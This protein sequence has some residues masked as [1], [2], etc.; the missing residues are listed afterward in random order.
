MKVEILHTGDT[1]VKEVTIR[2]GNAPD[3]KPKR[4]V[5]LD[6]TLGAPFQ[7][8]EGRKVDDQNT[9]LQIYKSEGKLTLQ[10]GD[11]DPDTTHVIT[12]SLKKDSV[13]QSFGINT[14]KRWTVR[15]FVK[16][17]KTVAYY[18]SSRE[19]H[20]KLVRNLQAWSV[21]IEKVIKEVNDN[22]GNSE[23]LLQTKVNEVELLST[24]ELTIPVYQGHS[25]QI[26]RV[27]IGLDPR[28][29]AVDLYLISDQLFELEIELREWLIE[30]A[31]NKFA[32][33]TFSKVVMS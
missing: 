16:F 28:N 20:T 25:K 7:F 22:S 9:H 17:I 1:P 18:F 21:K 13:L 4:S 14:E 33:H 2:K 11:T 8:L 32:P 12:G 29:N 30:S 26:F 19:D 24:F 15:D 27:E 5:K 6:G 23:Y 31:V 10:I 3:V